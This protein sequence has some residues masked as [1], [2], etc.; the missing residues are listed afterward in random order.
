MPVDPV[1]G[2]EVDGTMFKS[3]IGGKEYFFCC[4]HC[5]SRFDKDPGRFNV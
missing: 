4:P 2:M 3:K 1:C 5:K